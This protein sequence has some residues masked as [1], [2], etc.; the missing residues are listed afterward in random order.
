MHKKWDNLWIGPFKVSDVA[1]INSCNLETPDG[2]FV[3]LP[4]DGQLLKE[5]YPKT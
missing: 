1:G 2:E 5:Y 4:I 3:P